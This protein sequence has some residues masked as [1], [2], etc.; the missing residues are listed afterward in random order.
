M[1]ASW[2]IFVW[3]I[4]A[5]TLVVRTKIVHQ[6]KAVPTIHVRILA[7]IHHLVDQMPCVPYLIIGHNVLA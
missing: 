5:Y 2:A 1:I 4:A 7:Q 6:L 3:I